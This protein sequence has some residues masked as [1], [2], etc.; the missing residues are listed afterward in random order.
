[1]TGLIRI[2]DRVIAPSIKTLRDA[3]DQLPSVWRGGASDT[4][5]D[6]FNRGARFV[7]TVNDPQLM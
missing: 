5:K 4:G 7:L 6:S 2:D 1:L 3:V